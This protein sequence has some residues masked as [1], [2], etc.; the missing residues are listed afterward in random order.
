MEGPHV[1]EFKKRLPSTHLYAIID[2]TKRVI[3]K[4]LSKESGKGI[5]EG[6][7]PLLIY[8]STIQFACNSI[9][10][11]TF[12]APCKEATPIPKILKL[13]FSITIIQVLTIRVLLWFPP[14]FSF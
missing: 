14:V 3:R 10:S 2:H 1:K 6:T 4:G 11:F 12:I 5:R 8:K 7:I 9:P 13:C